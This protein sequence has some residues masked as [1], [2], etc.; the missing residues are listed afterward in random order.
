MNKYEVRVIT[1]Y[2]ATYIEEFVEVEAETPEIARELALDGEGYLLHE[3][4][5]YGSPTKEDVV[6]VELL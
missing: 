1:Y 2:P 6:S 5:E 3:V 4:V